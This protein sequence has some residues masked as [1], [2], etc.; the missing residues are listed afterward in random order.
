MIPTSVHLQGPV[1]HSGL[2]I[3]VICLL[4]LSPELLAVVGCGHTWLHQRCANGRFLPCGSKPLCTQA[5]MLIFLCHVGLREA[6]TPQCLLP[7]TGDEATPR[8]THAHRSPVHADT[9]MKPAEAGHQHTNALKGLLVG[10]ATDQGMAGLP[11]ALRMRTFL[12]ITSEPKEEAGDGP[13][14]PI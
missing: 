4:P 11:Q 1:P 3:Q 7:A 10:N 2:L 13:H 9:S 6:G 12:K 14:H 5:H 8:H